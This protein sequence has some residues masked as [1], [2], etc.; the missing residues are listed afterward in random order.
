M[1]DVFVVGAGAVPVASYQ[2][3][4][5]RQLARDA[6]RAALD[7]A[8]C[9]FAE[10]EAYFG[11]VA[12]QASPRAVI[13]AKQLGLTGI[14]VQQLTSASAS[15]LTAAHAALMAIES[16]RHDIVLVVGYD[17]PEY[18]SNPIAAQGFLPPPALFAHWAQR[19]AQEVG[20]KP[21]HLA[22]V[23]AKNWNYAR[24]NPYA[25]RRSD[26][27]VT[28]A[29]VLE[30]KVAAAPLT[31]M[32]CTPWVFGAAGIV[33]ASKEGL[34]RL[35]NVRWPLARIASSELQSEIYE[36]YHIFE[37]AIVGPP[38][39]TQTTV[40]AALEA[41]AIGP[42]DLD[43][44]QVH[45]AFA[46][47]ELVY[48]ELI[49]LTEPGE[50]ERLLEQGAFG[51]GSRARF[52]LAEVSTDGGLIARGHPGGPTG[53][54]QIGETLRRFREVETDRLGLCHMLGAGSVCIAQVLARVER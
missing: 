19:R 33:L 48:Y 12:D 36:P 1:R 34:A 30:S 35:P 27:E 6:G 28:V 37:G 18:K 41:A 45:D 11:G 21:E 3:G 44:V 42:R 9:T 23:A 51:P 31:V 40:A 17:C 39:I 29:E 10:I 24:Q 2:P 4:S 16:G 49:G 7:D 50:T 43:L 47:E 5:A 38:A 25:V 20:T 46:I 52:G 32:M 54:M 53:I 15:G 26:H 13:A 14:P 8:G 22:M